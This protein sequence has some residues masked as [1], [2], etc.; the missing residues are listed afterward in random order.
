MLGWEVPG[1]CC[2]KETSWQD[3][4][5]G[6]VHQSLLYRGLMEGAAFECSVLL[7]GVGGAELLYLPWF[8][9]SAACSVV[10][11]SA[12]ALIWCQESTCC[13]LSCG[14]SYIVET[15][16]SGSHPALHHQLHHHFE[17]VDE[18]KKIYTLR[19]CT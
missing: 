12:C 1:A 2:E 3:S 4:N 5:W 18:K 11:A 15:G 7:A 16:W 9:L 13:L 6:G 19:F 10:Q 8:Y 14:L 17:A